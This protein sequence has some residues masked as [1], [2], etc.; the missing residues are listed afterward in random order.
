MT[1]SFFLEQLTFSGGESIHLEPDSIVVIVGPNNAG[2]SATLREIRSKQVTE[3]YKTTRS[4]VIAN[5]RMGRTGTTEEFLERM[6]PY[7]QPESGYYQLTALGDPDVSTGQFG[8]LG[9]FGLSYMG[10]DPAKTPENMLRL[11]W[12]Q[13]H[14]STLP[15]LFI[16][17]LDLSTR[18]NATE[19][20]DVFN[21]TTDIPYHPI[22]K[23]CVN[24]VLA[25]R[26]SRYFQRAFGHALI[27]NRTFGNTMPLHCGPLPPFAPGE[28]RVSPS[29]AR[30]LQALPLLQNQGDGMRSFAGCL[31]EVT[32]AASFVLMIDEP[33]AFLHPPQARFLGTLLAKE[34]PAGRQLIIA[35]HSGDL[36]RGLL[37]ANPSSLQIIRLTREGHLNH[38][39][40]LDKE[41]IRT[42]WDDPILRFSNTLDSLFHEQVVLCEADGDCRFY[43]SL[44]EATLS[45]D[46]DT[47]MPDVMFTST[48]GKH[49]IPTIAKALASIGIPTR[50]IVD[51]DILNS[52]SPLR[53]AVE[54]LGGNWDEFQPRWKQ[55]K[56]G[57]E[58]RK[59]EL[60]TPHVRKEIEKLLSEVSTAIFPN[61]VA[62]SIREVLK[63][64]S[65]WDEA[66]QLGL[67]A[68]PKGQLRQVAETLLADL[69]RLGLFIVE[70]GEMESFVPTVGGHGNAWLAEVL[71]KDLRQDPHLENARKF[72]QGLFSPLPRATS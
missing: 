20:A 55:V 65:P 35:T 25:D 58:Q 27:V 61:D 40:T 9:Q 41:R 44:L 3:A 48:G 10:F 47:R 49:K 53:E 14:L 52:E 66:K 29:Y 39:R 12:E 37:D 1:A 62:K 23:M 21:L 31:L 36:L 6:A 45:E 17:L 13:G 63:R 71:R 8:Q 38:A 26:L 68:V 51:F 56:A 69:R 33:E 60:E 64:A 28:D 57:V 32:A 46:T 70:T 50:A 5:V 7:W 54:A 72:V 22:Q 16:G 24:P 19:P 11:I 15:N 34:K 43:A 4:H 30:K 59:P 18:I 42:L 67:G 2:K